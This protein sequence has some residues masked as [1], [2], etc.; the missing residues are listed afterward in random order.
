[1]QR[2]S[3]Q[4]P[5]ASKAAEPPRSLARARLGRLE[6][7]RTEGQTE[8]HLWRF[9]A[10]CHRPAVASAASSCLLK[11]LVVNQLSFPLASS[12]H[13]PLSPLTPSSS[14]FISLPLLTLNFH[15]MHILLPEQLL[16]AAISFP[17]RLLPQLVSFLPS[18]PS[19]LWVSSFTLV[20]VFLS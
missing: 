13:L 18:F 9:D 3:S 6:D 12:H 1:M 17:I 20:Y 16:F 5:S 8:S 14:S 19:F 7:G 10:K 2:S 15:F 4:P 11:T